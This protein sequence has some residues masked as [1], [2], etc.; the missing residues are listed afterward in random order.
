MRLE[1]D[2]PRI[3][4][5]ERTLLNILDLSLKVSA[6]LAAPLCA[7]TLV[8]VLP[9]M[10]V[11]W[12]LVGWTTTGLDDGLGPLTYLWLM[13]TLIFVEAPLASVPATLFLGMAMFYQTVKPREMLAELKTV[14]PQL[15]WCHLG[16]RGVAVAW[17]LLAMFRG[18]YDLGIAVGWLLV[19][20]G[21]VVIVRARRPFINE[22]ILLERAPWRSR[23]RS[24]VTVG[25]RSATLHDT[26]SGDLFGRWLVSAAAASLMA[27]AIGLAGWFVW[28]VVI[29]DQPWGPWML[30]V[31]CPV[32]MWLVAAY[33]SVVRF[34]S[35]LDLRIRREGWEV[36][37]IVLAAAKQ[38]EEPAIDAS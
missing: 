15:L 38:Y 10:A 13:A 32:A 25:R 6:W 36:E 11:N 21:Y 7:A 28:W 37:L 33:F 3:P 4:I 17:G 26:N 24:E 35:Y 20:T 2:R 29:F 5:R 16:L 19:L 34:L 22:I 18:E 27:A 23:R 9:L 30:H 8:M 14:L 12:W 1:L 31:V